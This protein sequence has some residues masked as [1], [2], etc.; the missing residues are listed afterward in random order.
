MAD[1]IKTMTDKTD[2][3]KK[4][5][6]E[7]LKAKDGCGNVSFTCDKLGMSRSYMY[8]LRSE[9]AVFADDWDNAVIEGK[10]VLGD[11]AEFHLRRHMVKNVVAVIF[12]LKNLRPNEWADKKQLD[13]PQ[14]ESVSDSLK[15]A[16]Y[17]NY[18]DN[19]KRGTS[20]N[21]KEPTSRE[22]I[23]VGKG[24]LQD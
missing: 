4:R 22:A 3:I 23:G 11:E 16:I 21:I 9:D 5:F 19:L 18:K 13:I 14:L 2:T 1:D 12:A 15:E 7:F 8:E 20:K 24:K 6:L 17:A 10:M